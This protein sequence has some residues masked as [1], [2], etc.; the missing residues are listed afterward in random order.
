MRRITSLTSLLALIVTLV[1]S[2]VL[3]VVPH[4]RVAYWADW[5]FMGFSKDQW[6][7][8][9][10]TVGTLFLI[11]LFVHLWLNWK[12]IA[13]YMKNQAREMVV[14]TKPMI[15]SLALVLF[16]MVGTLLGLPPMQ[17][18]LDLGASIK[19]EAVATYGTPPYGHAELSPLKKFCGFLGFDAEK[20]LAALLQKGYGPA[21]SLQTPVK[22][23]ATTKGVGPQQVL[24]DI[25][26]ALGSSVDPF[27]AMPATPPEGTG[28]LALADIC[29]TFGLPLQEAVA[30]LNTMSIKAEG[31][32]TMKHIAR[33]NGMTPKD[34]YDA[35]RTGP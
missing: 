14:M 17:Q 18:L 16:V 21:I 5:R 32:W 24:D 4:G 28:K 20:A 27:A 6:G 13:A 22:D 31:A 19:D 7:D 2:V 35:L 30:K 3:Y 34:V 1:T 15:I 12:P 11:V 25:R 9:H 26:A 33:E 23:I 29:K 10:I 8:M